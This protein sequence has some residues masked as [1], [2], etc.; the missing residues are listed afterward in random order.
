MDPHS[1]DMD[2]YPLLDDADAGYS[3]TDYFGDEG[4]SDD[5][6]IGLDV[7]DTLWKL[8]QHD[9]RRDDDD[10]LLAEP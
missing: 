8:H 1:F 7:A 4:C 10:G 2:P 9:S 5:D 3:Y 6:E